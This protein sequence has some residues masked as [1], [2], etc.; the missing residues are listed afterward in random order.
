M[1]ILTTKINDDDL[2][3]FFEKLPNAFPHTD[4]YKIINFDVLKI[5]LEKIVTDEKFK[6]LMNI[7]EN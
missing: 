2:M 4:K 5:I 6:T 1:D 7:F 3:E